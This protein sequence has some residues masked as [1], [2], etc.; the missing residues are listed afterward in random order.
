MK[1]SRCDV[2]GCIGFY[3]VKL[4]EG[5]LSY[6]HYSPFKWDR[7]SHPSQFVQRLLPL[8]S[9]ECPRYKSSSERQRRLTEAANKANAPPRSTALSMSLCL[10]IVQLAC[11]ALGMVVLN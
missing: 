2:R 7:L 8:S 4:K 9:V 1:F 10:L 3:D 5:S 6:P 11:S